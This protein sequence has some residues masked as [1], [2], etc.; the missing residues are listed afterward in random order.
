MADVEYL[1]MTANVTFKS[2]SAAAE[3]SL[4]CPPQ[5]IAGE[6]RGAYDDFFAKVCATVKP[7]D[8]IEEIFARD[9]VD[10]DWDVRRCRRLKVAL[11]AATAYQGLK[12]VLEPIAFEGWLDLVEAWAARKPEAIAEVDR[13]LAAAGLT[14]DA[15][16]AQTL[17]EHLD[18]IRGIEAMIAM[19]E[20]RRNAALCEIERHRATLALRLRQTVQQIDAEYQEVDAKPA[21]PKRLS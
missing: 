11:M 14:I 21:E 8:I 1:V 16:M 19:A 10:C 6:D 18:E 17:C 2:P 9:F 3:P 15:V 12:K 4:F 13:R 20:A 5:L 7:A